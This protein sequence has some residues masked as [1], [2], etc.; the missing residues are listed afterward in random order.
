MMVRQRLAPQH[1]FPAALIDVFHGY[2]SLLSPHPL[3]PNRAIPG[4]SIV[5][6]GDSSGANLALGL[7]QILLTLRRQGITSLEYH[8]RQVTLDLPAGL[9]LLS[10]VGE[11]TN[12]LPSY[13]H[14]AS[15]DVFPRDLTP[16]VL[17]GFPVCA[18][19]P[20]KPPRG[21]IYCEGHVLAHPIAS[22]ACAEDVSINLMPHAYTLTCLQLAREMPTKRFYSGQ[23]HPSCGSLVV[24]SKSLT[25]RR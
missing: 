24:K 19:W 16:T 8:G 3:A 9:T 7:L 4:S 15:H 21:N 11:L 22:P 12:T 5:L 6:A 17:P 10:A 1:P 14:N 13:K 25:V 20:S 18:I 23:D 2:M